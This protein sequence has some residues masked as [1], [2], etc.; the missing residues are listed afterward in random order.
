MKNYIVVVLG[1]GI[2]V[3]S[4]YSRCKTMP[5]NYKK[6]WLTT[7]LREEKGFLVGLVAV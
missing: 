3:L 7:S 2:V 1:G 4:T 5:E 6:S